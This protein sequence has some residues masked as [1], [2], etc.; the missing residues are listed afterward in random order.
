MG[1]NKIAKFGQEL[2]TKSNELFKNQQATAAKKAE[3][4]ESAKGTGFYVLDDPT[5]EKAKLNDKIKHA[6]IPKKEKQDFTGL[7]IEKEVKPGE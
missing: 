6:L 3:V 7:S 1:F 2:R 5:G 4:L